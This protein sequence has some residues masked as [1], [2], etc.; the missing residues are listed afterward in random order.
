MYRTD[1]KCKNCG[2]EYGLHHATTEQCPF[3]GVE[4]NINLKQIWVDTKF[5]PGTPYDTLKS[6]RDELLALLKEILEWDGI[7]PHSKERISKEIA[8]CEKEG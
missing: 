5:E 8:N 3:G 1:E 4:G 2:G 7:L 6:Q